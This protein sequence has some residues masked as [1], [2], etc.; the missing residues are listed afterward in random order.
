MMQLRSESRRPGLRGLPPASLS[1]LLLHSDYWR[2]S[3]ASAGGAA[4]HKEWT[5][6]CV[7][8]PQV[9]LLLNWSLMDD[10]AA[11]DCGVEVPRLA[12]LARG[13]DGGWEGDVD[14]FSRDAVALRGG[15]IDVAMGE[16]RLRFRDGVYQIEAALAER[17]VEA[18]LEL[19]PV[20]NPAQTASVPL[21]PGA[22][23]KWL[24]VPRLLASGGVRVGP[25]RHV[26]RDAPA[27]H[28]HDWGPFRW[29]GDFSWE[30][31]VAL[32]E[33][34]SVPWSLLFMRISDRGRLCA[35]SQSLLLWRG[36]HH[37]RTLHGRELEVHGH[38]T[39]RAG[40]ALRVPRVM[41]LV[42][43][44]EAADAP[45]VLEV[46][47]AGGRDTLEARFVLEDL[48]QIAVP[49]DTP[50]SGTTLFSEARAHAQV[51]GS[52]RG[53]RIGFEARAVVELNRA[54]A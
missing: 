20:A 19:R 15:G 45:N 5:H 18:H 14:T 21:G 48:A 8:A 52:I 43:P 53:E 40:R 25:H 44:G 16:S 30:W 17:P 54:P 11:G 33:D 29:G 23:M 36:A 22:S 47:A 39:L 6:F 26:F 51:E 1:T 31:G 28:D 3:P 10:P 12:M 35:R 24:V 49:N 42:A 46:H 41:G 32:P 38:G 34:P 2:R 9:D 4:G 7:F 50:A 37:W 13:P 27:Y